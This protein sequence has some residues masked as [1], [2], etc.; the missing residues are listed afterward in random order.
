MP[1]KETRHWTLFFLDAPADSW[2]LVCCWLSDS[3]RPEF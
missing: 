2:G 3:R 1:T